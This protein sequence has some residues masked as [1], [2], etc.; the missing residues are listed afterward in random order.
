MHLFISAN[1]KR[2]CAYVHKH[3][4]DH[5]HITSLWLALLP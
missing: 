1:E 4:I 5:A 2:M 3:C